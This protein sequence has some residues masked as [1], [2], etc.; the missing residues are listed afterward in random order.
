MLFIRGK[1]MSGVP[2]IGYG[3]DEFPA[4]Y[5]RSSG[6]SVDERVDTP[7]R[8][9]EIAECHWKFSAAA[10][11]VCVPVPAEFE[12]LSSTIESAVNQAMSEASRAGVRGKSVTPFLL[13]E[14]ETLTE[15][16]TLK[17]NR[18]LLVSNAGVAARIATSLCLS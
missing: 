17:T 16:K 14:M 3:T 4:F 11:L 5:S 18:A 13:S 9:A 12:I 1:A 8:V 6:L 2:I 7:V 10:V 15:G